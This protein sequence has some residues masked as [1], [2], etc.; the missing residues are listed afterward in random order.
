MRIAKW[1]GAD[2]AAAETFQK[3][4][5]LLEQAEGYQAKSG[6]QAR[7]YDGPRSRADG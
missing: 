3:A 7:C 6:I 2:S 4:S 1:A 5:K